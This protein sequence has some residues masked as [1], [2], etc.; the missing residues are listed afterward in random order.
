MS[1]PQVLVGRI[2][3]VW[4]LA[5]SIQQYEIAGHAEEVEV[6]YSKI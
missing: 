2:C 3:W 5:T 1:D 6:S 4:V